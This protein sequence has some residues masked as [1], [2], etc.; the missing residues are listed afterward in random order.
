MLFG[1]LGTYRTTSSYTVADGQ[2]REWSQTAYLYKGYGSDKTVTSGTVSTSWTPSS[3]VS[4]TAI[5]VLLQPTQVGTAF[6]CSAEFGGTS[7]TDTWNNLLWAIDASATSAGANI[8]YQLYNYATSSYVTVGDGYQTDILSTSDNTETQ[9]ITTNSQNFRNATGGWKLKITATQ[10][11]TTQFD[12]KLDLAK[13]SP[14]ENNYAVAVQEQWL[15]V[16]ASNVRQD[17]CIKTG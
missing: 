1:H 14:N 7:N 13:Y 15:T 17:L 5:G 3:T 2:T 16:N 9:T 4:W 11:T 10:T 8:T 6:A 12:L